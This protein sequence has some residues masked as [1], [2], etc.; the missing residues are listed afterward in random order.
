MTNTK[1]ILSLVATLLTTQAFASLPKGGGDVETKTPAMSKVKTI[2]ASRSRNSKEAG[3][4]GKDDRYFPLSKYP[5]TAIG[6]V[7]LNGSLCTGFLV[8]RCHV[9]TAN[10]CQGEYG[11]DPDAFISSNNLDGALV[12]KSSTTGVR[13]DLYSPTKDYQFLALNKSLGDKTGWL[14]VADVSASELQEGWV[15]YF[16]DN[17]TRKYSAAGYSSDLSIEQL[18][19]DENVEF[20]SFF[21]GAKEVIQMRADTFPGV[22]GGPIFFY[23]NKNEPFVVGVDTTAVIIR[24]YG[25]L[26]QV[27]LGDDERYNLAGAVP[28]RYWYAELQ[29]FI[30]NNPCPN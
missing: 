15:N 7:I 17:V 24:A 21:F 12:I 28:S 6:Q 23:N 19:V 14:G 30:K 9:V 18:S 4:Y 27:N 8:S 10:H 20:I 2:P 29:E 11:E 13:N 26:Y 25:D 5:F 3:I 22:S 16:L 1:L